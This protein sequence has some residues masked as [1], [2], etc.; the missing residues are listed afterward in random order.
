MVPC[1]QEGK[2]GICMILFF[3]LLWSLSLTLTASHGSL[4]FMFL[5][6]QILTGV[7]VL[8]ILN[9]E[10]LPFPLVLC[11]ENLTVSLECLQ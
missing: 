11:F 2:G 6:F 10:S 1:P 8:S 9:S 7:R 5:P 3:T 4:P